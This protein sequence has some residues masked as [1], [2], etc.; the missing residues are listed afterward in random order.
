MLDV[1]NLVDLHLL[2]SYVFDGALPSREPRHRAIHLQLAK[3]LLRPSKVVHQKFPSERL[4]P[5]T[6]PRLV[7]IGHAKSVQLEQIRHY[8]EDLCP[9]CLLARK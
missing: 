3:T 7:F 6:H 9:V 1:L 8:G 2:N 4:L 5:L